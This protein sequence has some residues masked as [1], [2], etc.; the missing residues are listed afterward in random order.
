M[1]NQIPST[2]LRHSNVIRIYR[3]FIHSFIFLYCDFTENIV[4]TKMSISCHDEIRFWL[5]VEK[6]KKERRYTSLDPNTP[7]RVLWILTHIFTALTNKAHSSKGKC[8]LRKGESGG[9]RKDKNLFSGIS[10]T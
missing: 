3:I 1:R 6:L 9:E 2:T 8:L 5:M 4:Q 7:R 10:I